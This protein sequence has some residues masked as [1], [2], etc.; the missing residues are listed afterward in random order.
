MSVAL[1]AVACHH[2]HV[3]AMY[4]EPDGRERV[5]EAGSQVQEKN[6]SWLF[7]GLDQPNDA[8][9]DCNGNGT[10]EVESKMDFGVGL[11]TLGIYTP[12]TLRWRCATDRVPTAPTA[13]P[14]FGAAPAGLRDG[15][16]L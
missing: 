7:W 3:T 14:H 15:G 9:A 8:F 4:R 16:A 10:A 6:V 5:V 11:L 13:Q 2:G 1:T 12:G